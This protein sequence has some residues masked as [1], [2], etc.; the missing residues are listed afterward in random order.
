MDARNYEAKATLKDGRSV[1]IRGIRSDDKTM[2]EGAFQHL[3]LPTIFH[4]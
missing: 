3:S 2:I 1:I 4:Y